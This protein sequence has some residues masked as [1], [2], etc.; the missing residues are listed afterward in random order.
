MIVS[1]GG[2]EER[3]PRLDEVRQSEEENAIIEPGIQ[4]DNHEKKI[5]INLLHRTYDT[6]TRGRR[7]IQN[8]EYLFHSLNRS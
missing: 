5:K 3:I 4:T 1:F 7:E 8:K 6:T 2:L